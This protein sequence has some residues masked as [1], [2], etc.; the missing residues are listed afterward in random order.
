MHPIGHAAGRGARLRLFCRF[1]GFYV[2]EGFILGIAIG[3]IVALTMPQAAMDKV[4]AFVFAVTVT[5][6]AA[7]V[8]FRREMKRER[9]EKDGGWP[10]HEPNGSRRL[11]PLRSE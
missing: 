4:I 9:G 2:R 7:G 3:L 5:L 10:Q 1:L 6:I 11:C 8:Q